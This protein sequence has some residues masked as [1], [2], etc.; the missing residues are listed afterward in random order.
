MAKIAAI[1]TSDSGVVMEQLAI[2]STDV[3]YMLSVRNVLGAYLKRPE[4]FDAPVAWLFS[5]L[6]QSI[7]TLPNSSLVS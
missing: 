1:E 6:S 4:L 5:K 2:I 7:I 3:D